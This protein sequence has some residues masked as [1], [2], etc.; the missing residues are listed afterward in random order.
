MAYPTRPTAVAGGPNA[1]DQDIFSA[2]DAVSALTVNVFATDTAALAETPP[3]VKINNPDAIR[4]DD[5]ASLT[6][7]ASNASGGVGSSFYGVVLADRADSAD[8]FDA[9]PDWTRLDDP[10]GVS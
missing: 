4:D 10:N 8:P 1:A 9:N 7:I 2:A 5:S 3:A 6:E